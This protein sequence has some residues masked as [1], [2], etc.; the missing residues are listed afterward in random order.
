MDTA[1]HELSEESGNGKRRLRKRGLNKSNKNSEQ[2]EEEQEDEAEYSKLK[3]S[4]CCPPNIL[5]VLLA[6]TEM[7]EG[8]IHVE[9]MKFKNEYPTGYVGPHVLRNLCINIMS[10]EDCDYYVESV[11]KLYGERKKG[12]AAKLLGFREVI[13]ATESIP[14][15][16]QP[17]K[18]LRWL[19]RVYDPHGKGEI[20]IGKIEPIVV[21][22][23]ERIN[24]RSEHSH[25]G[26]V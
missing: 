13:L 23:L 19:F 15:L 10:E 14:Y 22:I 3:S 4:I 1:K 17:D 6:Q 12:W 7:T 8:Q 9:Y 25:H 24:R 20:P 5:N 11:F 21:S 2:K 16:N 18:V 26:R